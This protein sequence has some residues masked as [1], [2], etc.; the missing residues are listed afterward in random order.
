MECLR[1]MSD[2]EF[3]NWIIWFI[4]CIIVVLFVFIHSLF[5]EIGDV[6]KN[7]SENTVVTDTNETIKV[8]DPLEGISEPVVSFVNTLRENTKR[9]RLTIEPRTECWLGDTA[10][11]VDKL[12][13]N[14]F[15]IDFS[16]QIYMEDT[17]RTGMRYYFTPVKNTDF[18]SQ[19]EFN[20]IYDEINKI[21]ESRKEVIRKYKKNK[22]VK[23]GLLQR[24]RYIKQYCK[25][26]E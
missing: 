22:K 26:N 8:V 17:L 25:E 13:G 6:N 7:Q 16:F 24:E 10:I 21:F 20:F 11:L 19:K 1:R 23:R 5:K 4:A 9:F 15:I 12:N 14:I 18:L 2:M 3:S